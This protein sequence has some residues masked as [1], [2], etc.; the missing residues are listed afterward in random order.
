MN[1]FHLAVPVWQLVVRSV[2]I[3]AAFL[4]ALR[5]FGKREVGQFTLFDLVLV[6]LAA[7]A[8]QPAITGPDN[9]V[10]GGLIIVATLFSINR[11]VALARLRSSR[12]NRLIEGQSRLIAEN[13]HWIETALKHEDLSP[14]DCEMALREHGVASVEEAR[15]VVLEVD[16]TI[17]VVPIDARV[18][19]S[20]HP[21]RYLRRS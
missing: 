2:L 5:L 19:R 3:Y 14:E 13:G 8:V 18:S 17:S 6:L 9:S 12:L 20:R 7:N 10:L 16:G 11:V 1:M 15:L 4:I 21:V